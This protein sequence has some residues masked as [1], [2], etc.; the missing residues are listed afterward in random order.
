M[1]KKIIPTPANVIEVGG[2]VKKTGLR[3]AAAVEHACALLVLAYAR[4]RLPTQAVAGRR[5]PTQAVAGRRR[6]T[7][8]HVAH[9]LRHSRTLSDTLE[10]F[11]RRWFF[12]VGRASCCEP[13]FL[14]PDRRRYLKNCKAALHAKKSFLY[15]APRCTV[16]SSVKVHPRSPILACV[17]LLILLKT[18]S[19]P[20][21]FV[22]WVMEIIY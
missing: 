7:L 14:F 16:K 3:A 20:H 1:P 17:D 5:R 2:N 6:P 21:L 12:D 9:A 8:S 11:P 10:R 22:N 15:G 18:D 13:G 19:G 4:P